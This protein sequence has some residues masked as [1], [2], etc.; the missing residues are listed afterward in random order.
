MVMTNWM[1]EPKKYTDREMREMIEWG[2]NNLPVG[3]IFDTPFESGCVVTEKVN[4]FGTF[5]AKDSEG[6]ECEYNIR[7][8]KNVHDPLTIERELF[9]EMF[10]KFN[11]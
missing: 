11:R 2:I 8:V 9:P 6:V 4:P 3:A 1:G 10:E 7:M 5:A